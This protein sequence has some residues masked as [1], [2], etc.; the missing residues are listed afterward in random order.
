VAQHG[1]FVDDGVQPSFINDGYHATA[2]LLRLV[3]LLQAA[4]T[5]PMIDVQAYARWLTEP[6]EVSSGS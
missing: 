5:V 4:A 2:F 1:F 3:S 6:A